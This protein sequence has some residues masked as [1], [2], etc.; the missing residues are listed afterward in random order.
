MPTISKSALVPF[1]AAQMYALVDDV[2]AYP[3]FLPWCGGAQEV[4]R[5]ADEVEASVDIAHSGLKKTF[6]TR[7]LI[8]KNKMIEMRLINGPFKHLHGFWRFEALA[9]DACKVS[10][11][12]EYEFSNKLVGMALGPVFSQIA[13]TLVDSFC[14]RARSLY[15]K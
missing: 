11:D 15:G 5:N 4:S 10:L 12:L 1:S 2:P 13:N 14:Q 7:N 9:E 3:Q 6:T 8:Q